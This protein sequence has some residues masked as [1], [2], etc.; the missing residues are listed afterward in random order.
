MRVPWAKPYVLP[1]ITWLGVILFGGWLGWCAVFQFTSIPVEAEIVRTY[2]EK[3]RGR[4]GRT[5]TN[6]VGVVRYVDRDGRAQTDK[7]TMPAGAAAGGKIAV[8]YLPSQPDQ[9]RQDS[10]WGIWGLAV[11]FG[12]IFALMIILVWFGQRTMRRRQSNAFVQE[13]E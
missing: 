2:E 12:G 7:L 11:L 10:F 6:T 8:R 9:C 1:V 13:T 3:H 4:R 5:Y